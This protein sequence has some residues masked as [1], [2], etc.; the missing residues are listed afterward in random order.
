MVE[1]KEEKGKDEKL[2]KTEEKVVHDLIPIQKLVPMFADLTP[3]ATLRVVQEMAAALMEVI[4]SS[5]KKLIVPITDKGGRTRDFMV[6]EGWQ[7]LG[8]VS[9]MVVTTD[10]PVALTDKQGNPNGYRCKAR[11]RD[12][13]TGKEISSASAIITRNERGMSVVPAFQLYS[14]VQTR[15]GSKALRMV[16]SHIVVLAGVEPTPAEEMIDSNVYEKGEVVAGRS[17]TLEPE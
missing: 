14:K 2:K 10:D 11:V 7:F 5:K 17:E 13:R 8:A 1:K 15:A 9:N 3:K 4:T 16:L 6:Y 12:G